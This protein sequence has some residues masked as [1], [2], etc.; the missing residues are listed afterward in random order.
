M[1]ASADSIASSCT[2]F[3]SFRKP[4]RHQRQQSTN[5]ALLSKLSSFVENVRSLKAPCCFSAE[6]FVESKQRFLIT[7]SIN[8]LTITGFP[9]CSKIW[10]NALAAP[11]RRVSASCTSSF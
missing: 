3:E 6:F 8:E 4:S 2:V 9:H 1:K 7:F 11:W 10:D 5:E